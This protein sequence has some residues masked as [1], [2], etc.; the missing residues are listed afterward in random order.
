MDNPEAVKS[1]NKQA[2]TKLEAKSN[3]FYTYTR[4]KPRARI[5][6]LVL[7]CQ[8]CKVRK[9]LVEHVPDLFYQDKKLRI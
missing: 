7:S 8:V 5:A 2:N 1:A 4:L 9:T 6:S 3:A